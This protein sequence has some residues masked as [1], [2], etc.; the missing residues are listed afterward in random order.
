MNPI[1]PGVSEISAPESCLESRPDTDKFKPGFRPVCCLHHPVI[2]LKVP[3]ILQLFVHPHLHTSTTVEF[4][5]AVCFCETLSQ[6]LSRLE[7]LN[8]NN[9]L[10]RC[11]HCTGTTAPGPEG[12]GAVHCVILRMT[13]FFFFFILSC[14]FLFY[15][16]NTKNV[17]IKHQDPV[18]V[19]CWMSIKLRLSPIWVSCSLHR[20]P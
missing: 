15:E 18:T 4:W 11:L 7:V 3:S 8:L 14:I 9:V 19:E 12:I 10:W 20:P 5:G 17:R 13:D 16:E 2:T 1:K 6:P